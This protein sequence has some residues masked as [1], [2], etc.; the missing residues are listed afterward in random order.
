[1]RMWPYQYLDLLP[2]KFLVGQMREC[3]AIQGSLDLGKLKHYIVDRVKDY[4]YSHFNVYSTLVINE[5]LR[6]EF[7]VAD[8]SKEK[9][10]YKEFDYEKD[11][12]HCTVGGEPLL[13][14]F[15]NKRYAN[16]V[17]Y[18]FQERLDCGAIKPEEYEAIEQRLSELD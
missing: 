5:M 6:R 14:D 3:L 9:L 7:R 17:R 16:Q 2:T 8:K 4:P 13:G 11:G 12:H 15:H 1:M 10:R 18:M